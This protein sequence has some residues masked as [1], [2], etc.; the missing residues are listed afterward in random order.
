MKYH[1]F[2]SIITL[3]IICS[4]CSK[5]TT[6]E[7]D[8]SIYTIDS[9][10]TT[11]NKDGQSH[12]DQDTISANNITDS[13]RYQLPVIFHILYTNEA[14]KDSLPP[15]RFTTIL[16]NV[17]DLYKG[18]IYNPQS[19][20][21]G[22]DFVMATHNEQ[23]ELLKNAGIE[24]IHWNSDSIS[25]SEF[26]KNSTGKY[27]SLIWEPNDYINIMV[28][29]FKTDTTKSTTTLGISHLPYTTT[30]H[31]LEGLSVKDGQVTKDNIKFAYCSSINSK[32]AQKSSDSWR[33]TQN[34]RNPNW[35]IN[36]STVDIS[37]TLAHEL[38]H[39]LGLHHVFADDGDDKLVDKEEDTDYCKDTPSYNRVTYTAQLTERVLEMNEYN[40]QNLNIEGLTIDN[41][42][43]LVNRTNQDSTFQ[44]HNL[45]DYS[46]SHSD[47]FTQ[48]QRDRI[49]NV[50]YYSPLIPG[51]KKNSNAVSVTRATNNEIF[52]LPIHV[53]R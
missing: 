3:L 34:K 7:L 37:V 4:S 23:G 20:D 27:K 15:E 30:E 21:L 26:M 9:D 40:K 16:K 50:L 38:G 41:F 17:N 28:Y 46:F 8:D 10:N 32:Y 44:S 19:V 51:P 5:N 45:M 18:N 31:K 52:D 13:Y 39:Y 43:E 24:Y 42:Y 49:R 36:S 22:I 35:N 33:Y 29:P 25:P 6:E 14:E 2:L 1:F 11:G 53:A 48:E 12:Q 47:L